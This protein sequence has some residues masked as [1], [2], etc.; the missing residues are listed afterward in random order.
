[1]YDDLV[2]TIQARPTSTILSTTP[3]AIQQSYRDLGQRPPGP[4]TASRS[5]NVLPTALNTAYAQPSAIFSISA[6]RSEVRD[7]NGEWLEDSR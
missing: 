6:T 4:G 7:R 1:M 2:A 5:R 3:G